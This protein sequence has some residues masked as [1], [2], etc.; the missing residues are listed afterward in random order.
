MKLWEI[1]RDIDN[2]IIKKGD[3]FK[4]KDLPI[5][6]EIEYTGYELVYSHIMDD[7]KSRHVVTLQSEIDTLFEKVD[8]IC[9]HCGQIIIKKEK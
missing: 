5:T 3:R 9:A 4:A 7:K 8:N 1:L 2:N 6:L